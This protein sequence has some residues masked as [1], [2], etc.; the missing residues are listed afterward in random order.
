M[1]NATIILGA[2]GTAEE[3]T[4][5]ALALLGVTLDRL[6]ELAARCVLGHAAGPRRRR[7]LSRGM[8]TSGRT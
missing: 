3:A 1:T 7:G 2:D 5:Q 8:G 4:P 6:R